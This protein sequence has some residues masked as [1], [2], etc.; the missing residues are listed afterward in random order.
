VDLGGSTG[1]DGAQCD[2][3]RSRYRPSISASEHMPIPDAYRVAERLL[4]GAY[5]GFPGD[6]AESASRVARFERAGVET[7]VDLTHPADPLEPY[8]RHLVR[9]RRVAHPIVDLGVP[10]VPQLTR[11]LDEL[12][13]IT[14]EGTAYVHCWGGIGRTG[15]IIGCWLVR[16]GLDQGD[17]IAR[18]AELRRGVLDAAMP[19]PQTPAQRELVRSWRR[20]S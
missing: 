15:T 5:P 16:H 14:A 12:D 4:A 2:L 20:G 8:E 6:P 9:A 1:R 10:T 13:T 3:P 7:F 11:I 18:I 19:S 17:A